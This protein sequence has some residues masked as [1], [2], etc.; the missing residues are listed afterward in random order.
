VKLAAGTPGDPVS[1]Y[2][3]DNTKGQA[4]LAAP[5]AETAVPE[6]A[7]T[8]LPAIELAPK[9]VLADVPAAVAGL[10]QPRPEPAVV[11]S[12]G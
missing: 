10:G 5:E 9:T 4:A 12:Q 3:N 2:V 11:K 1:S 7:A 6:V 8:P